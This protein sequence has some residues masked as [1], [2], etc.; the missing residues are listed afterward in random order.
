[1]FAKWRPL[2]LLKVSKV[3]RNVSIHSLACGFDSCTGGTVRCGRHLMMI[4]PARQPGHAS[5]SL[6]EHRPTTRGLGDPPS[7]RCTLCTTKLSSTPQYFLFCVGC[8][9]FSFSCQ[10][11]G[12]VAWTSFLIFVLACCFAVSCTTAQGDGGYGFGYGGYGGGDDSSGSST[13]D[14]V[15]PAIHRSVVEA[16]VCLVS[17]AYRLRLFGCMCLDFGLSWLC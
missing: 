10:R 1:M 9:H 13:G 14:G 4:L 17:F 12:R 8:G 5:L 7:C 2:R 16:V 15:A 6:S 11:T 3:C